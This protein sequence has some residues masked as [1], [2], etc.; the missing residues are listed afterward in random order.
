MYKSYCQKD[1]IDKWLNFLHVLYFKTIRYLLLQI[2]FNLQVMHKQCK[3]WS[4]GLTGHTW[5]YLIFSIQD[6][7]R[8]MQKI[9]MFFISETLILHELS[10]WKSNAIII[11]YTENYSSLN[12]SFY[13]DV[14]ITISRWHEIIFS[15]T[16]YDKNN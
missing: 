3:F 4:S 6:A 5:G 16:I 8:I 12:I 11:F 15:F 7:F 13:I 10:L 1:S 14:N 2:Y 9:T